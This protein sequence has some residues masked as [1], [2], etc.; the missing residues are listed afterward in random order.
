[1]Y[2]VT[3][4][5]GFVGSAV[6]RQLLARGEN[7]RVLSR[8]GSDQTNIRDLHVEVVEGE[9]QRDP[10]VRR[11]A[12]ARHDCFCVPPGAR[13]RLVPTEDD[14]TAQRGEQAPVEV[15]EVRLGTC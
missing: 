1:M 4:A 7:V 11:Y 13:W 10:G 15:L 9:H 2:L 6:T 3:G 8:A 5:T 14:G 12:L